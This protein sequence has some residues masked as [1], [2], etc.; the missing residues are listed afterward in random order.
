MSL[1]AV[2]ILVVYLVGLVW[3]TRW[4]V[5]HEIDSSGDDL[6]ELLLGGLIFS[7]MLWPLFA[8]YA[9]FRA[10]IG[11]DQERLVRVA[12]GESRRSKRER[13]AREA[14]DRERHVARLERELG[15]GG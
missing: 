6:G 12:A 1:L 10:T 14:A 15:I 9:L 7:G 13:L 8:A 3:G 5:R 4:F 2:T 11:E